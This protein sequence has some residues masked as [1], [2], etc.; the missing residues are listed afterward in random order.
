VTENQGNNAMIEV[1]LEYKQRKIRALANLSG[2]FVQ[3][4]LQS[5]LVSAEN[6]SAV[7]VECL[8]FI[9]KNECSYKI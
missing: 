7:W 1:Q 3:P 8:L 5:S 2:S 9:R 6:G 4:T